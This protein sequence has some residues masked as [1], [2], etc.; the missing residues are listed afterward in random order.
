MNLTEL[1]NSDM[2]TIG[3]QLRQG[4]DWWRGEMASM[5]PPALVGGTHRLTA[6]HRLDR[7]GSVIAATTRGVDT[8]VIEREG[9]LLRTLAMPKMGERDLSAMIALDADRIMPVT[10]DQIVIGLRIEGP[11]QAPDTLDVCV[12]A[13]PRARAQAIAEALR[14]ATLAPRHIGPLDESGETLAFDLAP[15][16]REAGLLPQRPPVARFW[17]AAVGLLALV[18]VG[19]CVLRDQQQVQHLQDLVDSQ[20]PALTVVRK[21][22]D[23]LRDNARRV[24][25]LDHKRHDQQPLRVMAALGMAMPAKAWISR[26]EWNDK[27]VR[28]S[29]YAADGVNVVSA[30][31]T[32][33]AFTNVRASRA[34][35]MAQT[36][37]GK[38][39]DLTAVP[40]H[41]ALAR[42]N[43]APLAPPPP[44]PAPAASSTPSEEAA[45]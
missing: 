23:R 29:G 39:F 21:V 38:P 2:T 22:E 31:K 3:R 24:S 7:D 12:G 44:A 33:P 40:D 10:A 26:L 36:N 37:T 25:A 45:Q 5:L 8:L 34:E 11:G 28:L 14:A 4:F 1:L 43:I 18:N 19:I 42:G 13:L 35:A 27:L 17:W 15:A 20:S 30:L 6:F 41:G 9:C 16:M 32:S